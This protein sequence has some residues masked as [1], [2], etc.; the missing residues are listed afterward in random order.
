MKKEAKNLKTDDEKT[1]WT[2]NCFECNGTVTIS[3][4]AFPSKPD[5]NA[6]CKDCFDAMRTSYWG[7]KDRW[8]IKQHTSVY[9]DLSI[10][11]VN[12]ETRDIRIVRL[13]GDEI[14]SYDTA[15]KAKK[16]NKDVR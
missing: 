10:K 7:K 15:R 8:I 11:I 6:R 5:E 3:R 1:I 9:G 2:Y 12:P 4:E 13:T 14:A 16:E